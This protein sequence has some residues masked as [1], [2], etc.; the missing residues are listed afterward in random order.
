[1]AC[2]K[3]KT[4]PMA[5]S[6]SLLDSWAHVCFWAQW[7]AG[8][9]V[10]FYRMCV[11][12]VHWVNTFV[13]TG[14]THSYYVLYCTFCIRGWNVYAW[15]AHLLTQ[16]GSWLKIE[17][18][19]GY[20]MHSCSWEQLPFLHR[21]LYADDNDGGGDDDAQVEKDIRCNLL[22][23]TLTFFHT[24]RAHCTVSTCSLW[25]PDFCEVIF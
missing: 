20:Q 18:G 24:L 13:C 14:W 9:L 21:P 12:T 17:L 5:F 16:L 15:C 19:E 23:E 6:L 3:S 8:A 7:A 1:M 22:P 2:W 10:W 4:R 25:E 11:C